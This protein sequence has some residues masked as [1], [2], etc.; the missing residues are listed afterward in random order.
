MPD[1]RNPG[2]GNFG[3]TPLYAAF[4]S[5]I[6]LLCACTS[7]A[8]VTELPA[9]ACEQESTPI[10]LVQ[11]ADF[12]SSMLERN[13]TIRGIATF[14]VAGEG[15]Y[16][17]EPLSDNSSRTSDGLYID[18]PELTEQ[19]HPGDRLVAIGF[20]TELGEGGDTLTSLTGISGF[21]VCESNVP[22]PRSDMRLPLSAQER[23]S[24][25][26]MQV[27]MQ[28]ALVVT[29]VMHLGKGQISISRN[30]I[31]PVPTEIARP[32]PDARDQAG[33]NR[34]AAINVRLADGDL[35]PYAVGTRV[36]AL[37]GVMGHDGRFPELRAKTDLP[38]MPQ[39]I[40]RITDVG[41]D[42]IR[43]VGLNLHNYFNG[44]G[45]GGGFPTERGARTPAEFS[46]QRSRLSAAIGQIRPHM[47]GVMELEN[48][49]FRAGS[50][51]QDFLQDLRSATEHP[52]AVVN[53]NAV[54][55]G[56]DSI[57]V[58]IFYRSDVLQA[59]GKARRELDPVS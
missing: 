57:T 14:V 8:M 42:E 44:D 18:S 50:A 12:Q 15:L 47:V 27:G 35:Q 36:L 37:Q 54:P 58:G 16:L 26:A 13:V 2:K 30:Y 29:N 11:G 32:G 41:E 6:S 33:K 19:I 9:S 23:E 45:Y 51:A 49:G 22:L 59:A 43:I 5:S 25:E 56:N 53:P 24:L 31:L 39:R 21:R 38:T 7:P 55:V 17:E 48:D 3:K 20:V 1:R 46:D 28:Q 10:A 34:R 4:F 40:Y 52:W